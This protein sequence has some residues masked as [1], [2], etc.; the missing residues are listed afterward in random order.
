MTMR[1]ST[2]WGRQGPTTDARHRR[3]F[4]P[5]R[6]RS[7]DGADGSGRLGGGGGRS[8]RSDAE[9]RVEAIGD[10][11]GALLVPVFDYGPHVDV[12]RQRL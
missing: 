1:Y 8:C 2:G 9:F 11:I 7:G 3:R 6:E 4:P 10:A 5:R 12:V